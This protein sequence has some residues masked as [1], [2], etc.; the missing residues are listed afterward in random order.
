MTTEKEREIIQKQFQERMDEDELMNCMRC[1]FCLPTCPTYIESGFQESHSPR[2]RI[3]LMKAVVDRLI[4]PDEDVER[5][6]NMCLG[7]RACE[8]VC[9]SGVRYGH[10]LEEARDII[11]QHKKHSFLVRVVRKLVFHELF[12]YPERMRMAMGLIGFYQRSGLQSFARKT[13]L[14]NI[15]PSS[16]RQMEKVLPNVPP[17]KEMKERPHHLAPEGPVKR[18]V[19]FFTGCL[20]DTMFM[21][22]NDATMRLLQLAGCEVIIPPAQTCCG[23]LH[24]HGGEKQKAKELAKR[25]IEAFERLEVDDIVTNA[26]GCGAFLMEY[27]HLLKDEAEWSERAKAFVAKIK[28][29]SEVLVELD[30]Q[31][32]RLKAPPQIVTY[33]DSCHLRNVMKTSAA[34][35]KLLRAIEG[36]EFREMKDADRCCGSAGIYNIVEPEMSMQILDYKMEMAKQTKAATIVTANPGCLLQVKLGIERAGLADRVR[37]VHLVDFLLEAAKGIQA[38]EQEEHIRKTS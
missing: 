16:L 24:G 6:L 32:K 33:Q 20:M 34:P 1:G 5:S 18:R 13:G 37:A 14:L 28:D 17:L 27:D 31:Q 10:L 11:Q 23:A 15:L 12:P 3:A 19:A 2:G 7:C 30:F 25:N 38:S 9:P 4:E 35:R 22:T 36:V 26:G 21:A 8:P 29:I